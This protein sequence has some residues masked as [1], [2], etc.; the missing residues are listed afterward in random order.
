[1][2]WWNTPGILTVYTV[3]CI[4]QR[5]FIFLVVSDPRVQS[6]AWSRLRVAIKIATAVTPIYLCL[7]NIIIQL[8]MTPEIS[9]KL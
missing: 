4:V 5:Y 9:G 7:Y 8:E 6:R 3:Q 2:S 1:M